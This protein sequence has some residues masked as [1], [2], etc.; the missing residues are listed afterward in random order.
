MPAALGPWLQSK[1]G[2]AMASG[3]TDEQVVEKPTYYEHIRHMFDD[4][5]IEHMMRVAKMDL[6]TYEGVKHR[7]TDVYF[8]TSSGRMPPGRRWSAA[9]VKTFEN[10]I[11]SGFPLGSAKASDQLLVAEAAD[12][13]RQRKNVET[14]KQADIER[15][16]HV[17]TTLMDR[18]PDDPNSYFALASLH[19]LPEPTECKHHEQRYNPW[20][21]ALVDRFE[22]GL[23]TV[24]GHEDITLPYWDILQPIPSW[25][26]E[27]PFAQFVLP[28][29][30]GEGFDAG[31]VATRNPSDQIAELVK[32]FDIAGNISLAHASM[33]WEGFGQWIEQAHDNGHFAC[34][35]AMTSPDI[36]SFNPLF[37]F[38]HCNWERQWWQ[39]QNDKMATTLA[40]FRS[41]I[42]TPGPHLWLDTPPFNQLDPFGTTADKT[43]DSAGYDYERTGT[44]AI[45]ELSVVWSGNVPLGRSFRVS[46]RP[47]LSVRVKQLNRLQ[48]KGSFVVHLLADG[49]PVAK[50]VFFQSLNPE[51]C[52]AC[53]ANA[54]VD[55]DLLVN[56]H[57]IEGKSLDIRIESLAPDRISRWILPAEI[58]EPTINVRELLISQ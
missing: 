52:S 3:P 4:I 25:L 17:F 15:L 18:D 48:V 7:A 43:I 51:R 50:Q 44:E 29:E 38:F 58:G 46:E 33:S 24:P 45:P 22:D 53:R 40:S 1:R 13:V 10:W 42:Q 14:L 28:R 16:R 39:W 27:P 54:A 11:I 57:D 23:R 37:W 5:D 49:A 8:H 26:S 20:H 12:G 32:S 36:A 19:W 30:V 34:G 21:R 47:M 9:R 35:G 6:G 41:T 31:H 56:R 55:I 2:I